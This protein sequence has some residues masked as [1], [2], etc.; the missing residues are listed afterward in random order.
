MADPSFATGGGSNGLAQAEQVRVI[1]RDEHEAAAASLAEAFR[2]DEVAQYF[3]KTPDTETWT[4]D[5][6]WEVHLQIMRCIVLAHCISGLALTVGPNHAA[7]ALW[8][9]PGKNMDGQKTMLLSGLSELNKQLSKE[10]N[11]R[12]I[13]FMQLLHQTKTEVLG[14]YDEN[15]WYLVYIGTRKEARGQGYARMLIDHV[16]RQADAEGHMCYLESSD[17]KNPAIYQRFGFT[18][19][20]NIKL[21]RGS[22]PVELDIMVRHPGSRDASCDARTIAHHGQTAETA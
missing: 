19:V 14:K 17:G 18:T 21:T 3:V 12:F 11:C 2:Y 13:E 9:P 22:K 6:K 4:L 16:T 7:V 1:S 15:S 5:Q 20:Q 8:M 10:G